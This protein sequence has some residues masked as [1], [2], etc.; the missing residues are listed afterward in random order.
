MDIRTRLIAPFAD[1]SR[2]VDS[3]T[4]DL[5]G[6]V[7]RLLLFEKYICQSNRLK[8]IPYLIKM[9]GYEGI[10]ALLT[11]KV[12]DI[13][14][15]ISG[16]TQVGQLEFLERR[17]KK[18]ILPL[19]S[20]SFSTARFE[21]DRERFV[22][23]CLQQFHEIEGLQKKDVI[24][25]KRDT[26]ARILPVSTQ[27]DED[28]IRQ[29]NADMRANIPNI[30]SVVAL[31]LKRKFSTEIDPSDIF[32]QIH[33]IDE[34][35]FR[36]ETNLIK[37]FRLSDKEAHEVVENGLRV[38]GGLNHRIAEMKAFSALS[39]FKDS[40]LPVFEQ[41]ID[42]ITK[43]LS[44]EAQEHRMKRVLA[45]KGFQ[46]L[47]DL[48]NRGQVDL[49]K[50]LEVRESSV[51]RE[52]REWLWSIDSVTDAE[53]DER[54]NGM[55]EK[56]SWFAH[57][58]SGKAMRWV[59]STGIGLIPVVGNV[60]GAVAGLLDTFLL[61][62]VL[63]TPGAISFINKMYPSIFKENPMITPENFLKIKKT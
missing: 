10:R 1:F 35:D 47:D 40:E 33:Q 24:K 58:K 51:C 46:D 31:E 59:A 23:N 54:V 32:I 19:G 27:A 42:F 44:P 29:L 52:F 57:G 15:E 30:R 53:I 2:A 45:L 55:R 7:L 14:C 34:E 50:L 26:V 21:I 48:I 5:S 39:G 11:S 41:K 20:Y 49:V 60:A 16:I 3:Q 13:Q 9:F 36:T 62:K 12:I 4:V 61:E 8:E 63:P 43:A 22:H 17:R 28:T 56:L 18:G 25:L 38:L 37:D 6:F